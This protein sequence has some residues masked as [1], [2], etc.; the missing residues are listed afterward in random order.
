MFLL[1][2]GNPE[3]S[4]SALLFTSQLVDVARSALIHHYSHTS[5]PHFP[6]NFLWKGSSTALMRVCIP[7]MQAQ[8]RA[9]L[10]TFLRRRICSTSCSGFSIYGRGNGVP[11]G[12]IS[13]L[14]RADGSPSFE[15]IVSGM[16]HGGKWRWG[17]SFCFLLIWVAII[18]PSFTQGISHTHSL[19]DPLH[20]FFD[21]QFLITCI[22]SP[23][24]LSFLP[25]SSEKSLNPPAKPLQSIPAK[26]H[27][28][29]LTLL[30]HLFTFTSAT[31]TYLN[32]TA[33]S[34]SNGAST[35][36]C[37]QLSAPFV[38]SSQAGTAGAATEQLGN[39]ANASF[40]VITANFNGGAHRAPAVQYV[41]HYLFSQYPWRN[42]EN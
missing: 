17:R 5:N 9:F 8:P 42:Q 4:P 24:I 21:L 34:A 14:G 7:K 13:G 28:L 6:G 30:L 19:K 29:F 2:T 31:L 18:T 32:L 41:S 38:I 37:W 1:E 33:I 35:L 10:H 23:P 20:T 27:F 39:V 25:N 15:L 26:M 12:Y 3:G 11:H 40:S 16:H 22:S 36:E